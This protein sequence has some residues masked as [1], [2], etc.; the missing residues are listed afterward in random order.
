MLHVES[1]S[2]TYEQTPQALR[3]VTFSVARGQIY[4]L[5]G[6]S[7]A[8]KSTALRSINLLESP[9]SGRVLLDGDDLLAKSPSELRKVRQKIGMIF[10]HFNLL[11][12][13]TAADNVALALEIA[14]IPK[15][16]IAER[17][18]ECL[19]LVS[20]ENKADAYPAR[21]SGG[22]KQR[23]AIARAIA[24]RPKL[25][26]ADEPTSA[27][28][29]LTK[30]EVLSCLLDLNKRL[31]LSIVIA[32]HE[33]SVIRKICHRASLFKDGDIVETFDIIKR[34]IQPQTDFGKLFIAEGF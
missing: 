5:I 9:D 20:L 4:G 34:E 6:L 2:K 16:E 14:G 27:L 23:V 29:P 31:G 13:R 8:G 33:M 30:N 18:K 25:L 24:N 32:S 12:N 11:S 17:V 21:L 28:D 26:L 22:Q 1:I 10:Q 19:R 7:G 15:R 3:N